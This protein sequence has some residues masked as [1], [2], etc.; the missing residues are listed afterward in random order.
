[1]R[2]PNEIEVIGK[3]REDEAELSRQQVALAAYVERWTT[4]SEEDTEAQRETLE[5]LSVAF[6]VG[7]SVRHPRARDEPVR[8]EIDV[9]AFQAMI[10][11]WI[12]VSPEEAEEQRETGEYLRRVLEEDRLGYRKLFP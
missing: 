4:V 11:S 12:Y 9:A 5:M 8:T 3:Q 10:D 6:D 7:G 1:M 2:T